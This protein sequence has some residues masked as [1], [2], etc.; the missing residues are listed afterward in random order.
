M[1]KTAGSPEVTGF[2]F[3][4]RMGREAGGFPPEKPGSGTP[5]VFPM[6]YTEIVEIGLLLVV[7]VG[8]DLLD[9]FGV[10]RVG[11]HFL[12]HLV[13]GVQHRGVVP[14]AEFLADVGQA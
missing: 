8:G 11:A 2:S 14:V 13:Q 9:L 4:T 7:D 10:G 5:Q 3:H 6:D 1:W 12:L